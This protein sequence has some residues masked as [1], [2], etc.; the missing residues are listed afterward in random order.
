LL[1]KIRDMIAYAN[2][3]RPVPARSRA[4]QS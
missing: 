2:G 1:G 3:F 4:V